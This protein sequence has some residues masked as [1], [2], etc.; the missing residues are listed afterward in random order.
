MEHTVIVIFIEDKLVRELLSSGNDTFV[1]RKTKPWQTNLYQAGV[2][3]STRLKLP[4]CVV[5]VGRRDELLV[6]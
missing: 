4:R 6:L 5:V 3:M 1:R 2:T